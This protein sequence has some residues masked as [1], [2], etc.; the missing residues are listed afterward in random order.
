MSIDV[1][2]YDYV[3]RLFRSFSQQ[4]GA[5]IACRTSAACGA[6]RCCYFMLISA[7]KVLQLIET[8]ALLHFRS[9]IPGELSE[10]NPSG[11][12]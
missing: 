10:Q 9:K 1:E 6:L 2:F 11:T 7:V 3:P 12:P 5:A 4:R 8:S